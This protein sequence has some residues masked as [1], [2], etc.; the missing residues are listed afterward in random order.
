MSE[1]T[2]KTSESGPLEEGKRKG[3]SDLIID[4]EEMVGAGVHLGHKKSKGHPKMKPYIFAQKNNIDIIDL[5][6]TAQ[7]FKEALEFMQET[8]KEGKKI[9][10]VGTKIQI[11][12]LLQELAEALKMPYFNK[13]WLGGFL[14][15]FPTMLK[16]IN[17]F[18]DLKKKMEGG[19]F[20]KYTK[21]EK[22]KIEKE[23]KSLEEKFGGVKEITELPK[24][25]F[26]L[27]LKK[28]AL[29]AKEAKKVGIP[30]VAICDTD[31]DIGLCDF[32]IPAN[33]DALSSV[34]YILDKVK[35]AILL[36]K[37]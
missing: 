13:R 10:F 1:E 22:I 16:R 33:D 8:V 26:I 15:N 7:N 4:I 17:Y 36:I 25:I 34:K 24:A 18:N 29:A 31:A 28:D 14:T 19:E 21:K 30:V 32:A 20:E 35:E 27:D 12:D 23:L 2:K 6:K 37:K 5:Q 3:P 9:F 11:K